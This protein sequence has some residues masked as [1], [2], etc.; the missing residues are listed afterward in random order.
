MTTNGLVQIALFFGVLI[1]LVKPLGWYMARVHEG[2]PCG[3][4]RVLGPVE[5]SLYSR[6]NAEMSQLDAKKKPIANPMNA[7]SILK[8]LSVPMK[9]LTN[10]A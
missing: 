6:S 7:I 9:S 8:I 2:K 5:K 4:D 3:L 10:A 1:A